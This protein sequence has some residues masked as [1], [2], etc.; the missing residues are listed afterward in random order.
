MG[1]QGKFSFKKVTHLGAGKEL[2]DQVPNMFNNQLNVIVYNFV[3]MLSH[4]RTEM[5]VM[6]ELAENEAA[7][8]SITAS[9]FEHSPLYEAIK[10][11]VNYILKVLF[12]EII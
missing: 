9:W 11:T 7:Y 8:R 6:K 12:I 10:K 4:V 5:N 1:Y 3:D 2:I